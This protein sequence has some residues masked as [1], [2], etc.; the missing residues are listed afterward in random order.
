MLLPEKRMS[1]KSEQTS[2]FLSLILRHH[3]ES[4][5]LT[6]DSEGWADLDQLIRLANAKG[7]GLSR[8]AVLDVVATN[9]K[10]RFAIDAGGT[11][12]RASQGHS[13]Q[14]DLKLE[15]QT[16]PGVLYHGTATRFLDAIR[17]EGLKPGS[18]QHVHLSATLD[19]ATSV[20]TRHGKPAV[21]LVRA[22]DMHH[23]G[24]TFYRSANGVWLTE[25]V[26]VLYLDFPR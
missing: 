14:V 5:G 9:D 25:Q 23:N 7:K 1:R 3:P 12:I 2:K 13:V 17:S 8:A 15:P 22:A 18:R 10:Q 6:L 4:I 11:R 19:T 21:L 16:P 24:F 20:G 26:P